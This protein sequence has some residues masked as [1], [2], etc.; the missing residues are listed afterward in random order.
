[1]VKEFISFEKTS[2]MWSLGFIMIVLGNVSYAAMLL[3]LVYKFE[4]ID[5]CSSPTN[6][7]TDILKNT[8]LVFDVNF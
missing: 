7:I 6:V 5:S 2:I 3:Y 4:L 8:L 1:M